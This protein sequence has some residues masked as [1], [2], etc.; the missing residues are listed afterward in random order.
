MF[1][2]YRKF[3][4]EQVVEETRQKDLKGFFTWDDGYNANRRNNIED[5]C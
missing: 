5:E 3:Q 2:I 4:G 1:R